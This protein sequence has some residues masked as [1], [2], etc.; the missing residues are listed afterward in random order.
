MST[1]DENLHPRASGGQWTDK[2]QS[3]PDISLTY[4]MPNFDRTVS[5]EHT[6]FH[7]LDGQLH[8]TNGPAVERRDGT[9]PHWYLHDVEI[10]PP[11]DTGFDLMSVELDGTQH[12]VSGSANRL[13]DVSPDGRTVFTRDGDIHRTGG[14]AIIDAD[15]TE[16]WYLN[17]REIDS[18]FPPAPTVTEDNTRQTIT[19]TGAFHD[20]Q[21]RHTDVSKKV[22]A[23]ILAAVDAGVLPDLGMT[24]EVRPNRHFKL[25]GFKI[26]VTVSG[27]SRDQV[28]RD[29]DG[30]EPFYTDEALR[31]H[32][33]IES[34][35]QSH[36]VT[37]VDKELDGVWNAFEF[38]ARFNY[39]QDRSWS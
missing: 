24:Y 39:P 22:E 20:P 26:M 19:T 2:A 23:Q 11:D 18:P 4:R 5:S 33:L 8:R 27:M 10:F 6:T 12:W 36:N 16:H 31:V 35:G 14:P 9:H 17:D 15:G 30:S 3:A 34:F 28:V 21:D 13:V 37:T 38:G 7:S 29:S 25:G 32:D 1:H